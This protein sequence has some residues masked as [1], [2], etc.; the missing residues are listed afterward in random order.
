MDKKI[1]VA[2]VFG[3]TSPEHEVSVITGLQ[4]L[5]NLDKEKFEAIP[6]YVSKNGDCFTGDN[7][8]K[9]ETYRNLLEISQKSQRVQPYLDSQQKGFQPVGG[10]L[11]LIKKKFIDIDVIF[12]CF[13]G[14]AGENG[15]FQGLFEL[16]NIPYVGPGVLA[17][18]T[19]MDK[20][21]TKQLFE[22]VGLSITKYY[23]FYRSGW[24]KDQEKILREIKQKL[25]FP[26]FI[27]PAN[28]GSSIGVA[29][30]KT[31]EELENAIEVALLFDRKVIAEEAFEGR[32][33]NISVMGNSG[34]TLETSVC[35]EVFPSKDL[36]SYDD[37][38]NSENSKSK[39]MA[40]AKR[41]VPAD[42]TQEVESKIQKLAKLAYQTLDCSG[43]ARIDFMINEKKNQIV[44]LEVNTIPG[45]L[46]FYLWSPKGIKFKDLLTRL[47][48]LALERH[49]DS[50]KN[51][52]SFP[53]NILENFNLSGK[54][55]KI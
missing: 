29:K 54:A 46:S 12:P 53:T 33:I 42:L 51:T 25:T 52:T 24:E 30:V 44:I 11:T 38:Y 40:S 32:E 26:M 22:Q 21:V 41:K 50:K 47:I 34:S 16:T 23:W 45:S 39:G 48:D 18:A 35:E 6:I 3:G 10:Q 55:S 20:V 31:K 8:L 17:S 4:A 43:L 14:G 1:R 19:G 37:K 2:V 49:E 13:H 7:L 27:K 15:A 28:A 9:I 36:L 5:E